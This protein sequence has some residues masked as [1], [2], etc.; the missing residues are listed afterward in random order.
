MRELE[1]EFMEAFRAEVA[2][3]AATAPTDPEG[4]LRWFED[5]KDT[6]PGQND[7]L[8]PWLAEE[9]DMEA[10]RWFLQQE[11]AGE[12]GFDDLVAYTQVKIP[13]ARAKLELAAN[14]WDEMGRGS[15][16]GM[17]GPM[18]D[19]LARKLDLQPEIETTV[20]PAL[21]LGNTL[22]AMA[23][24]RRYAYHSV[25]GLGV[26]ELTAPWRAELI[27]QGL[28]RLGVGKERI[29]FALHATLD[30]KHSETW[31]AEV[32]QPLV[33]ADPGCARYIAEGALMRLTSGARC[34]EAYRAHLWGKDDLRG[35]A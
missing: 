34:F 5:L 24:H 27:A 2:E 31:N 13:V 18:L 21:A 29:Y 4:M 10:M 20:G 3:R 35:A 1:S 25:G 15:E 11:V 16:G 33:A 9:A 6:G 28:K 19:A 32:L 26:V 17:H 22:V 12:A 7:P 30:I 23:T 8:F 14:Y